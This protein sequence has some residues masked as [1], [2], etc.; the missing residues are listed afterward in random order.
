MGINIL[1]VV[2]HSKDCPRW[3]QAVMYSKIRYFANDTRYRHR[4]YRSLIG[5]DMW[6]SNSATVYNLD[7]LQVHF[8]YCKLLKMILH[9]IMQHLTMTVTDGMRASKTI[10]IDGQSRG[11]ELTQKMS[12]VDTGRRAVLL[13]QLNIFYKSS[14]GVSNSH[15][16][17]YG[18][19]Q[20]WTGHYILQ[21]W[22]L[23]SLLFFFFR[24][25]RLLSAVGNWMYV[26]LPHMMWPQ[27]EFR[28][29]V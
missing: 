23:S 19:L 25:T 11:L 27:C 26:I 24:F 14:R 2:A 28:M 9:T 5:S 20:Q 13:Q 18:R 8:T 15:I 10:V 4:Y 22:L 29:Q 17:Y 3:S 6:L 16:R 1:T 21:L 7:V 12:R